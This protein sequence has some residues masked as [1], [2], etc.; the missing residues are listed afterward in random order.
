MSTPPRLTPRFHRIRPSVSAELARTADVLQ[1][2]GR[3]IVNLA[4]GHLPGELSRELRQVAAE[5]WQGGYFTYLG[6][7]GL[8]PLRDAVVDWLEMR[9][10]RTADDV[11][12]SP[13]SRAALAAVLAVVTGPGDVVLVDGAAWPVFHQPVAVSGATPLPCQPSGP[14]EAR[15]LKLT[16]AD[17][18]THLELVRGV[19]A[20]VLASPVNTTAQVYDAEEILAIVEMCSAHHVFCIVDRLYGRLVYDGAR[21]P[22]FQGTPAVRDW[23]VL[24]DGVTRAF[25]GTGGV[26]VGWACGPRDIIEAA[27]TAQEYGTGPP[28]RVLQRVALSALQMPYDLGLVEELEAARDYLFDQLAPVPGVRPWPVAG[29]PYALLDCSAWMG[30][31]TPVGWV[32]E[33]AGDLAD[34]L[35]SEANV[36][37]TPIEVAGVRGLIRVSFANPWEAIG[38][39]SARIGVALEALHPRV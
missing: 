33:T 11:L 7:P 19:R 2:G 26:R 14:P 4:A 13:G 1:R 17:V 37:V 18:R 32:V 21:L 12:V 5:S 27:T 22:F 30:A 28:G 23:L 15:R 36:L 35:L 20:L 31:T 34:Y 25:R 8:P 16:A 10:L 24:I 6:G 9:H 3:P 29:T 39:A 38:D